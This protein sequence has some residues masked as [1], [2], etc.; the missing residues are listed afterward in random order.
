LVGNAFTPAI[1]VPWG[2][3]AL[4]VLVALGCGLLASVLPARRAA[5]ADPVVAL[6]D[7]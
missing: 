2:R 1:A 5:T 3:L 7:R 4:V 6:A